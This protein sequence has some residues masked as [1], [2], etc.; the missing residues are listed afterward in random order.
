V[1]ALIWPLFDRSA[2]GQPATV[3]ADTTGE[4]AGLVSVLSVGVGS[5]THCGG[6]HDMRGRYSGLCS[7]GRQGISQPLWCRKR[8]VRV[9]LWPLFACSAWAQTDTGLDGKTDDVTAQASS[10]GRRLLSQPIGWRARQER[11]LL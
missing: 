8:V 6:G 7:L 2:W 4:G 9:P 5:A 10:L 1:K 3:V 11:A